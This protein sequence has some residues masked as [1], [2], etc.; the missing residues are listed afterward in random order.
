ML[1]MCPFGVF[2]FPVSFV[3]AVLNFYVE[4]DLFSQHD[5]ATFWLR[6][7][8]HFSGWKSATDRI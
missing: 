7:E 2:F 1:L 4:P 3:R 6:V 8:I 5:P